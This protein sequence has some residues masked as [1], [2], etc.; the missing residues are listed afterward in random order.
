MSAMRAVPRRAV[1]AFALLS[2]ALHLFVWGAGRRAASG[3]PAD[4]APEP[5]ALQWV[6]PAPEPAPPATPA[7]APAARAG[8]PK[9]AAEST[10]RG[11]ARPRSALRASAPRLREARAPAAQSNVAASSSGAS[12]S[13]DDR[14]SRAPAWSGTL[15]LPEFDD[16]IDPRVFASP[17]SP[18]LVAD[19]SNAEPGADAVSPTLATRE[20]AAPAL[21]APAVQVVPQAGTVRYRI[22]YG[23]PAQ[24]NVVATLEQRFELDHDR[25]RLH[26]A[27]RAEG[28]VSWFYRGTLEQESSGRVSPAGLHPTR[29]RERRGEREAKLT[30]LDAARGE[31]V[32]SNGERARA[33]AGMQDRLSIFVQLGLLLRSNPSVFA[34]GATIALPLLA[35]SRVESA[36]WRVLGVEAVAG[37][38]R[39]VRAM[40]LRRDPADGD[41]PGIDVWLALDARVLPLRVRITEASGRAL[42]Q[43]VV[44]DA[45]RAVCCRP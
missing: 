22:H 30:V 12:S 19:A 32:F 14:A 37:D 33:Q 1:V 13:A 38:A 41:E 7:P 40:H 28:V 26:S 45:R 39:A 5:A 24:G 25:Y 44:D 9:R 3:I 29:Y 11:P 21:D 17:A 43:I 6:V 36:S 31:V 8:A 34:P 4:D 15:A 23:D 16:S 42:D 10:P 35:S 18:A 2:V 20:S 27:G